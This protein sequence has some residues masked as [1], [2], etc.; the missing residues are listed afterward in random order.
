MSGFQQVVCYG[1]NCALPC[2]EIWGSSNPCAL[3]GAVLWKQ[4]LYRGNQVKMRSLGWILIQYFW[5][6]GEIVVEQKTV[7]PVGRA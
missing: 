2:K 3:A 7:G 5:C 6:P 4:N 1:L